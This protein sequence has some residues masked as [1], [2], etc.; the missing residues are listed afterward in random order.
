MIMM[1]KVMS[2]MTDSVAPKMNKI[3][4]NPYVSS[5]QD[6]ILT[7]MPLIFIG[8]IGTILDTI[9][10]AFP[11]FPNCSGFAT[12][13]FN[14][15]SLFL[16]FLIPSFIMEKKKQRRTRNQ[17]GL[18]GLA[19]FIMVICPVIEEGNFTIA[20]KALGAGGMIA[21]IVTGIFVGFVMSLF[22]KIRLFKED[23]AIP[24]FVTV[25][26]DTL[27]PILV[28]LLIGWILTS[29]IG[30]NLLEVITSFFAPLV[31]FGETF[32]GFVLINFLA[33]AFLYSFGLSTW[34]LYSVMSVIALTGISANE[35][36][37]AAGMAA[38]NIHVY[39][40]TWI[41]TIG[42]GGATF[43]LSIMMCFMAKSKRLKLM[44]K[45]CI[46]PSIFN[47]NE[48]LVYGTPMAFNPILMIPMWLCG[49][50]LPCITWVVFNLSLVPIPTKVFQMWYLPKF[51]FAFFS[52]GSIRGTLLAVVLFAVS[53]VI[54]WPFFKVYD[55]QVCKEEA[56]ALEAEN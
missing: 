17:A 25:W 37:A 31:N 43:A 7:S 49:F 10:E 26:F 14:L 45:T 53:W 35:A 39:E 54:Y 33:M 30:L 48:P 23:S 6:A 22:G 44:G 32:W 5:V 4:R 20:F 55:N 18:A 46:V 2:F 8:T 41:M 52:T 21:A 19:L 16:A 12:F 42:G 34:V 29:V 13:S 3:T 36:A 47:I 11:S 24:D 50:I 56:A 28:L 40:V 1:E 38:T 51:I 9:R 27:I 15:I